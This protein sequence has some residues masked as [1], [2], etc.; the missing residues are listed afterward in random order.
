MQGYE[1]GYGTGGGL[2][3]VSC[4]HLLMF[5]DICRC[6]E[7]CLDI[8]YWSLERGKTDGFFFS[9][10]RINYGDAAALEPAF[11]F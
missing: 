10:F 9:F 3:G 4:P 2:Q 7:V 8:G 1:G 11:T 6:S 5:A